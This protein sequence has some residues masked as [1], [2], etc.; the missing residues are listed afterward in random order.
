MRGPSRGVTAR[1][2]LCGLHH[3][4]VYLFLVAA[5]PKHHKFR[6]LKRDKFI[7][8]QLWRSKPKWVLWAKT[9]A[10]TP[11]GGSREKPIS[12]PCPASRGR[13]PSLAH[14]PVLRPPRPPPASASTVTSLQ[15]DL[16]RAP[17]DD[18]GL[19]RVTRSS[20]HLKTP[21]LSTSAASPLLCQGTSL[22]G[23]ALTSTGGLRAGS[24]VGG[25]AWA[26]DSHSGP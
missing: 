16:L 6:G 15:S 2:W 9:K 17:C 12:G 25:S 7:I 8:I 19:T 18:S 14:S 23:T 10:S 3:A 21:T 1:R 24:E 13:L 26:A 4:A 22:G 20:P 11:S 5:E